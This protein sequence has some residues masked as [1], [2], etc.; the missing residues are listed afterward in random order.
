VT[1][2]GA[3]ALALSALLFTLAG[4]GDDGDE[5]PDLIVSAA[6]SLKQPFTTYGDAFAPARV[7]LS[8]AGSDELAAQIRQGARPDVFAAANTKLPDEL[9]EEGL[10]ERPIVFATNRLVLAVPKGGDVDS[11]DDLERDGVQLAIGAE[12]VP[13]GD[14]TRAVLGRLGESRSA[15]ILANVRSNEPDVGGIVGKLTQG[16]ADAGFV[17]ASDVLAAGDRLTAIDLPQRLQ[18]DV[19]YGVAVV[20]G[21]RQA[22]HA[23]AFVAGLLEGAGANALADAGFGSGLS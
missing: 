20:K 22:E 2:T 14:Y 6:A 1:R 9:H 23:R 21:A 19:R 7:R 10:V 11:V 4:C 3:A 8:F 18:A 5:R 17:Y 12:G 15:R 13:V 16:A